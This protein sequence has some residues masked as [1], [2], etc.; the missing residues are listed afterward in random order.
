[1]ALS[2]NTIKSDTGATKKRKRLGRGNS[3]GDGNYS[4]KG[5]KGQK[6]RSGVSGL[7]RLG[8][9]QTLLRTPKV[10]GFKSLK[11]KAQVVN[12]T[13]L[14]KYFSEGQLVN[15]KS[16]CKVGLV[17]DQKGKIKILAIGDLKVKK[18]QFQNISLSDTARAKIEKAGGKVLPLEEKSS[19][20]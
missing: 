7:K 11:P 14:N 8:M 10:R 6:A 16:L 13:D 19:K 4:G 20:K 12:V 3:S 17:S 9:K 15:A 18:L 1:M 2:L 5:M